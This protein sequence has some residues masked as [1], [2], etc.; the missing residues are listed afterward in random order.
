ML[1]SFAGVPGAELALLAMAFAWGAILGSFVNVVV[2]RVPRRLSVVVGASRCP[3]CETPILPR[4]N[5]PV[6]GWI[7]LGGRCRACSAAISPR[8]PLVEA[9]AG[10]IACAVAAVEVVGGG[11]SLP[12]LGSSSWPGVDRLLMHGDFRLLASW[13]LHA[14]MLVLLLAWSLLAAPPESHQV[15]GAAAWIPLG[16]VLALVVAMPEVGP[17]GVLPDGTRWPEAERPATA[18]AAATGAAVGWALGFVTGRLNEPWSRA[19]GGATLGWQTLTVVVMLTA[20]LRGGVAACRG[21][22]RLAIDLLLPA[23]ATAAVVAWGPI[24][25]ACGRAWAWAV[26]G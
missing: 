5:I 14:G 7:L 18:V 9:A 1:P 26:G 11:G 22:S 8:Y 15:S 21:V 13:A 17:P 24:R 10:A 19:I 16:A 12:W 25:L 2:H 3:N 23:V 20:T 6:V 4:D